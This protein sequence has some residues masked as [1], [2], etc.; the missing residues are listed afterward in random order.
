M[1]ST[2]L[3]NQLYVEAVE[4]GIQVN[5]KICSAVM[6]GFGADVVVS[7]PTC[8]ILSS[9]AQLHSREDVAFMSYTASCTFGVPRAVV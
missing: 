1:S 7:G 3:C 6:V 9:Q 8:M 5:G 4:R 2:A